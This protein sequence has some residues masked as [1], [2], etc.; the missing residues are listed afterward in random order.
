MKQKIS[1]FKQIRNYFLVKKYPFLKPSLGYGCDMHYHRSDYK[2]CYE[3]TWLDCLPP[4]WRKTFG[5]QLCKEIKKAIDDNRLI[6]YTVQQVKEK[7]GEL[8][9]YDEGGNKNTCEIVRKYEKL[10]RE[11]CQICGKPATYMTHRWIGYYCEKCAKKFKDF[12]TP[13][14]TRIKN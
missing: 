4:G 9:W 2:Y 10:S 5:K 8:C 7:F 11:T 13:N 3:E 14:V 12:N 1:L 6:N